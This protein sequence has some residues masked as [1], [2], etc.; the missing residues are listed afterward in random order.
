MQQNVPL[1]W[2][3]AWLLFTTLTMVGVLGTDNDRTVTHLGTLGGAITDG[4]GTNDAARQ[5]VGPPARAQRTGLA[6]VPASERFASGR[7]ALSRREAVI[8][9]MLMQGVRPTLAR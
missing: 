8:L 7:N 2:T 5:L 1:T 9:L 3:A 6:S 4:R